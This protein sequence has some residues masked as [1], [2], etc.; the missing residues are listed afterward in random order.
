M[1]FSAL[2]S[3]TIWYGIAQKVAAAALVMLQ[4]EVTKESV[5]LFVG[6]AATI[7]LRALTDKPLAEK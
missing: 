3:K 4:G 5:A 7:I 6:G 2:K 1:D